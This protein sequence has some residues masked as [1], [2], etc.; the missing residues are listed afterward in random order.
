MSL[1]GEN[2]SIMSLNDKICAFKRKVDRWTV[3]VEMGRTDMFPDLEEFMEENNLSVNT[4][5][6]SIT[7]HLQ[8]LLEC[9]NKFFPEETAPE[10]HDWIRS[11]LT[12]T[13]A[14]HLS[15]DMEDAQVAFNSKTLAEHWISV[16]IEISTAIQGRDGHTDVIWLYIPVRKDFLGTDI[17]QK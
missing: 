5:K 8:A 2:T 11:P 12:V 15:S 7:T 14:S 16:E 10:K 1:Q 6:M 9:F 17:Y 4:V 3:Q 13:T